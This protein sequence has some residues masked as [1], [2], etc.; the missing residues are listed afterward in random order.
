MA[1]VG[2]STSTALADEEPVLHMVKVDED[3]AVTDVQLEAPPPDVVPGGHGWHEAAVGPD[4]VPA[5]QLA[6][7]LKTWPCEHV[8]EYCDAVP[9]LHGVH[10]YG[11]LPL[12]EQPQL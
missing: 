4:H 10:V 6:Q 3:G 9:A 11:W 7:K 2:G 8:L 12:L 5:G 1:P